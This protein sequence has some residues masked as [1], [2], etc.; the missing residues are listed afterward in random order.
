MDYRMITRT[1]DQFVMLANAKFGHYVAVF[2]AAFMQGGVLF[3]CMV[4]ALSTK[5]VYVGNVTRSV[6]PLPC[7]FYNKLWNVDTSPINE[8][9]LASQF[10]SGF[11]VNASAIAAFSLATVFAA[12]ACGQ[13]NVLMTW[14]TEYVNESEQ[15]NKDAI[16]TNIGM[17][18][19]YHLRILR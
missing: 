17:V 5:I 15:H 4:T 18:I 3:Y 13:L 7:A 2:C 10:L 1:K 8:I 6:Y 14:V 12:H 16:V 11:I 9:V 19:D